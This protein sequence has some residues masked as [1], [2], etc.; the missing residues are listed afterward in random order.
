MPKKKKELKQGIRRIAAKLTPGRRIDPPSVSDPPAVI[1]TAAQGK[2]DLI[3]ISNTNRRPTAVRETV[4][5]SHDME[6]PAETG[7]GDSNKE[8]EPK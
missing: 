7:A 3:N 2:H 8:K 1:P 5:V 4:F 6:L